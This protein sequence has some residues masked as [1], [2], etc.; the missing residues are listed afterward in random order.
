MDDL[1]TVDVM[2]VLAS[3]DGVRKAKGPRLPGGTLRGL[4]FAVLQHL[5]RGVGEL[6][7]LRGQ[8]RGVG[9]QGGMTRRDEEA[10]ASMPAGT[11]MESTAEEE[12]E[13]GARV[14]TDEHG[15]KGTATGAA[16]GGLGWVARLRGQSKID[17]EAALVEV[18]ECARALV[19]LSRQG[20]ALSTQAA[21]A[22]TRLLKGPALPALGPRAVAT[23]LNS[24][25]VSGHQAPP[26]VLAATEPVLVRACHQFPGAANLVMGLWQHWSHSPDKESLRAAWTALHVQLSSVG[27]PGTIAGHLAL[28]NSF[29]VRVPEDMLLQ[30][31]ARRGCMG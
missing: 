28:L 14:V 13:A 2:R 19:F 6:E 23:L 11:A 15:R 24:L 21:A 4:E 22:A 25:R 8:G 30:M 3:A 31:G 17:A 26:A 1:S 9:E 20:H 18:A 29:K 10:S 5:E 16:Q 7:G 27:Q 12:E